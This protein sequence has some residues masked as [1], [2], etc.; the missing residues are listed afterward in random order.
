M[1]CIGSTVPLRKKSA[2]ESHP[3]LEESC[4]NRIYILVHIHK[5]YTFSKSQ[6]GARVVVVTG[7]REIDREREDG[8]FFLVYSE[9]TF[10]AKNTYTYIYTISIR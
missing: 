8:S 6:E 10:G 4:L 5:E 3:F 9:E 7:E 2:G 1:N